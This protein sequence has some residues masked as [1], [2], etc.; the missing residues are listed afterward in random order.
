VHLIR[1]ATRT[2]A[3]LFSSMGASLKIDPSQ[4]RVAEFWK[5]KG[6]PLGSKIRKYIRK[7]EL[8]AKPFLCIYSEELLENKGSGSSCG[9][10]KCLCPKNKSEVG[11]PELADHEWCSKKAVINGT[12]A[13]I[14]AI[15]GFWLAGLVME[16]IYHSE[17]Q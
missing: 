8:P 7:G 3:V 17:N 11:D 5:V 2:K 1:M 10:E 12:I 14:T 15:F 9:T 6:C 13:H 16:N 4:I